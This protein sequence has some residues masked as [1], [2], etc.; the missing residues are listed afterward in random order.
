[1]LM[2]VVART[3]RRPSEWSQAVLCRRERLRDGIVANRRSRNY[4]VA[5]G[6]AFKS[7]SRPDFIEPHR[8]GARF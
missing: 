3:H 7:T 1:M 2:Q 6:L 4:E 5:R 8:D